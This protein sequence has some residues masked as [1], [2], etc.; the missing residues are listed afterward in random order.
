MSLVEVE[1][2]GASFVHASDEAIIL[3][4]ATIE[5]ANISAL[6]S[7]SDTIAP[8][9][10]APEFT[11]LQSVPRRQ[12]S[13]AFGNAGEDEDLRIWIAQSKFQMLQRLSTLPDCALCQTPMFLDHQLVAWVILELFQLERRLTLLSGDERCGG[14]QQQ[15]EAYGVHGGDG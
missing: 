12:Q 13:K 5:N 11:C 10:G 2:A 7:I 4:I 15:Q 9:D 3:R 6:F 1:E 14:A 8:A